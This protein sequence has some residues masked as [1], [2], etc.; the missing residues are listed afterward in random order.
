MRSGVET[1]ILK[2]LDKGLS[3]FFLC[4]LLIVQAPVIPANITVSLLS[5][6]PSLFLLCLLFLEHHSTKLLHHLLSSLLC[7]CTD[8]FH[9]SVLND[10]YDIIP[11]QHQPE[12]KWTN[13][14]MLKYKQLFLRRVHTATHCNIYVPVW[15]LHL[16]RLAL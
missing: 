11:G 12:T 16:L 13:C 6:F 9:F 8:H 3:Q 15:D 10:F 14:F 2:S 4:S 1:N 7:I 5:H